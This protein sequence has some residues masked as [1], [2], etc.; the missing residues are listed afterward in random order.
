MP[1]P[2]LLVFSD[3]HIREDY[4][5][6]F[7]HPVGDSYFALSQIIDLANK[8]KE[9]FPGFEGIILAGD[10]FDNGKKMN[11]NI[12]EH[13]KIIMSSLRADL[14]TYG[15]EGQHDLSIP[16]KIAKNSN[17]PHCSHCGMVRS[18]LDVVGIENIN[19]A[20]VV[21]PGYSY[22]KFDIAAISYRP[23]FNEFLK[24][25]EEIDFLNDSLVLITHQF[26]VDGYRHSIETAPQFLPAQGTGFYL[27]NL[28]PLRGKHPKIISGD[29]HRHIVFR[30]YSDWVYFS[31]SSTYPRSVQDVPHLSFDELDLLRNEH[32]TN[33][34]EKFIK[35]RCGAILNDDLTLT[36]IELYCRPF[37]DLPDIYHTIDDLMKDVLLLKE[38]IITHPIYEELKG[39]ISE[40]AKK[41]PPLESEFQNLKIP[42][43]YANISQ[44]IPIET[45]FDIA[46]NSGVFVIPTLNADFRTPFRIGNLEDQNSV[47]DQALMFT[48]RTDFVHQVI[49]KSIE[50]LEDNLEKSNVYL[51]ALV[52]KLIDMYQTDPESTNAE[53]L[54]VYESTISEFRRLRNAYESLVLRY[55]EARGCTTNLPSITSENLSE[56][57]NLPSNQ[58]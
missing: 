11:P 6:K 45:I 52:K 9:Q 21:P 5:K 57:E 8:T 16:A 48:D 10:I 58:V 33:I 49:Q 2:T 26:W 29:I 36:P 27:S 1:N 50:I 17:P 20:L 30:D 39:I 28:P 42:V 12:I 37:I 40:T 54:S 35:R 7:P 3:L 38:L 53:I 31:P 55:Y 43:F 41:F 13:T 25:Y 23:T 18:W 44:E 24:E 14:D 19:S 34:I 47:P 56:S 22:R 4:L 32:K 51:P 46:I 15:I